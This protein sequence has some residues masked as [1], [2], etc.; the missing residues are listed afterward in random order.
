MSSQKLRE[1]SQERDT[2]STQLIGICTLKRF[3]R[4]QKKKN[5][6]IDYPGKK[7]QVKAKR[8]S[9]YNYNSTELESHASDVIA[10][11]LQKDL[12]IWENTNSN[13][14]DHS[15]SKFSLSMLKI[16]EK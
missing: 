10:Q 4:P 1:I 16:Q 11:G 3:E 9:Q 5:K 13:S 2:E 15:N 12:N 8:D 6:R 14:I 7:I